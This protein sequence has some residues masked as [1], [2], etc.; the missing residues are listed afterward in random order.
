[1]GNFPNEAQGSLKAKRKVVVFQIVWRL[2]MITFLN[3]VTL[4]SIK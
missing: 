3:A 2:E 4:R 1:M